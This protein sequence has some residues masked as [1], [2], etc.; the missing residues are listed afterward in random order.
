LINISR[1]GVYIKTDSRIALGRVIKFVVTDAK[2]RK[3]IKLAG[4]VV[5]LTSE[6]FAVSFERR[7]GAERRYDLDRRIGLDRRKRHKT[8]KPS[9]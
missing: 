2:I 7:S 3:N 4:W 6:G 8:A 5:R 9:E 1:G